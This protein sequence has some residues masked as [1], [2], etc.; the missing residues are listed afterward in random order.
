MSEAA[1]M[2]EPSGETTPMDKFMS[3]VNEKF[4]LTLSTYSDLYAW[5]VSEYDKFWAEVWDFCGIVCSK[6]YNKV[7]DMDKKITD[8]PEWFE[9]SSL[10]FAENLLKQGNK[11]DKVAIYQCGESLWM[12][13]LLVVLLCSD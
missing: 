2:W 11:D 6:Q 7:V 5:S 3:Q 8:I 4:G 10:N 13:I 12:Y 9:G 1:L